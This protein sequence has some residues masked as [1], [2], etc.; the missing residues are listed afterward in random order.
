VTTSYTYNSFGEPLTVTDPLGQVTTNTYDANGNLL[1]VTTPSPDGVAAGSVTQFGYDLKGE[2]TQITDPLNHITTLAYTPAGLIS[3]ISDAQQNVTSYE[4]DQRG[5]RTAVVD[6]LQNRTT[7]T[8]DLG[9][10]LTKI[11]Y[12]DATFVSFAYDSRGR[13]TSVTDQNGKT[14]S[15]AYDDAD[16]LTS[17]T[18]AAAHITSYAYDTENNLLSIT[19]AA[20]H[21]TSFGYDAFGRVTQTTF[22]STLTESY[23]Y[24]AVGTLTSKTDRKGQTI[25]YV[26][27][28]LDRLTHKGYPD[29]TGVDYVYDLAGKIKQVTDPTGTYGFAYDNMGRLLGTTT[30]YAFIPGV[31]FSN[32]YGYDAAS[33]RT[34][35]TAP[36]GSTDTYSYDTLGRLSNITDSAAGQF[37]FSYDALSRRTGLTRPNAVNTTYSYDSLSRLL[38]V[39]HQSGTTTLDGARYSYDLAGNRTSKTNYLNNVTEQYAYDAIY[40]LTQVTQGTTTSE[41]YSYDAVGNRLSSLGWSYIYNSSNELTSTSAATYTYDNNG[42]TLSKTDSTG[43]TQY[44]WDFEDR[45]TSTTLSSGGRVTFNYDPFGRRI[46]KSSASGTTNYLY[47][48]ANNVE[49]VGS[50]GILFARYAHGEDIDEPLVASRAGSSAFY[51]VDGLG[52]VT[53][54]TSID[55]TIS[56]NFA[57][58]SFGNFNSMADPFLQPFRYTG[59]QWDSETGL[60]YYRERYYD[61]STGRFLSEDPVGV[62]DGTSWFSYVGNNPTNF[63]D[64]SGLRRAPAPKPSLKKPFVVP[65]RPPAPTSVANRLLNAAGDL[66]ADALEDIFIVLALEDQAGTD[67][68]I[69]FEKECL[70]RAKNPEWCR[71]GRW[72]NPTELSNMQ[73]TN[74][75]Q[76]GPGGMTNVAYPADPNAYKAAPKG[77]VYVEFWVPCKSLRPGGSPIW[78]KI[79]GPKFR[80]APKLG[81][82]EMPPAY[83]IDQLLVK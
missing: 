64:P 63:V 2:L 5:N 23:V 74:R 57:Y 31:T 35:F 71:V 13:R 80:L 66:A 32:S 48:G 45:L 56:N 83:G 49:E 4:Y 75:V 27:D 51:E 14:T 73:A 69:E 47:D 29:T 59:R 20:G 70:K 72:M 21:T 10:R 15:Y 8:Y 54:L 40:Q 46:H 78:R 44:T 26:Y 1:T 60:Y 25:Q 28:A 65:R 76:E 50:S 7:F 6:A 12:P 52:S 68:E 36:H 41:S 82:T 11:T 18:D 34:S 33:N 17:V 3:S 62:G 22:P 55:G 53:S 61:T 24:S 16:R 58:D 38:S 42:N 79:Y 30:Q 81:I 37:G 43:T 9:N 67:T 39:L 19:D 77:D